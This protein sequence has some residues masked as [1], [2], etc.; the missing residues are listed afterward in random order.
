MEALVPLTDFGPDDFYMRDASD[1]FSG[2]LYPDGTNERPGDH[3]LA[4]LDL[5]RNEV[6]PRDEDG[7][8]DFVNGKIGFASLGMSNTTQEFAPVL[9]L[10]A[11]DDS[12]NPRVVVVNGARG[13][14]IADLWAETDGEAWD[15][16]ANRLDQAGIT[17]EQLQVVWMKVVARTSHLR[18]FPQ[19]PLTAMGF[20]Q[21][22]LR[23]LKDQYPNV[24]MV[25]LSSR[26]YGGYAITP[27]NPEPLAFEH[28]FSVKWL[29]ESQL[30][31]DPGMSFIQSEVPWLSWG[32]YLWANG[33]GVDEIEGGEPGR[34]DGLEWLCEDFEAS[35]RTHPAPAGEV[36]VAEL[37]FN[38]LKQDCCSAPWF[39][40]ASLYADAG[41]VA[42]A[43]EEIDA[44]QADIPMLQ[45]RLAPHPASG[46]VE[47]T[48]MQFE[49]SGDGDDAAEIS[50]ATLYID[51][52]QNGIVDVTDTALAA[53]VYPL[54]DG[55]LDL[56]FASPVEIDP[57]TE[58]TFLL[59]YDI[60]ETTVQ[61]TSLQGGSVAEQEATGSW[62]LLLVLPA[63]LGFAM[64]TARRHA[65]A[66]ALLVVAVAIPLACS[67][68]SSGGGVPAD[69][70]IV[71][72][73]PIT[74]PPPPPDDPDDPDDPDPV[75]VAYSVSV[76]GIDGSN[77]GNG[78]DAFQVGLPK[79]GRTLSVLPN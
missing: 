79:Q 34:L 21:Q 20:M 16:F 32:P 30:A 15:H 13:G 75:P 70:A 2:G 55:I 76:I 44:G 25:F 62:V 5:S 50:A 60:R 52:D 66:F 51:E 43:D 41:P 57:G 78:S 38:W 31:G 7:N 4:G 46:P 1:P 61:I 22:A 18:D 74:P 47:V 58:A 53:G 42:L 73:D 56:T 17:P 72:T 68:S 37:L 39:L 59:A 40:G 67:G 28:G 23:N 69:D 54:D 71:V 48:G 14:L 26:T 29:V 19:G 49:A 33:V 6:F 27:L 65:R 8:V 24:K 35:D 45:F 12:V 11:N 77:A 36:K 9:D 10:F 63:V 3:E 64:S